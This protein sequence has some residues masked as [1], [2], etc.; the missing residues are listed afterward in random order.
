MFSARVFSTILALASVIALTAKSVSAQT[1]KPPLTGLVSMGRITFVHQLG[2]APD[3][4]L[5]AIAAAPGAFD[6][7]SIN[8][9]WDQLQPTPGALDT[10]VL[11]RALADV[12]AYNR[13]HPTKPLAVRLRV[14]ASGRSP[15]WAKALGGGPV[16]VID[17]EGQA[18]T[19]GRFW[20]SPFQLAWERLQQRLAAR[21]D[22]APLIA[23]VSISSCAARADEPFVLPADAV[24][25]ANLRAA[26]FTDAAY[27]ACLRA[28]PDAYAAWK[29]TRIDFDVSAFRDT[30]GA[31]RQ[32]MGFSRQ[33][34]ESFRQRLGA[35]AV[36]I[37]HC[38]FVPVRPRA[39]PIFDEMRALGPEIELQ[40]FS[41][42]TSYWDAAVT[43]AAHDL[44][45]N[46]VEVW[47]PFS[48][49]QGFAAFPV[50]TLRKWS[51]ELKANPTR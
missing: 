20:T 4:S 9:T 25:L 12:T 48:R 51:A 49:F 31:V 38:L 41:P 43:Y 28:A 15:A 40:M 24:S 14:Y 11:D 50:E 22:D 17:R 21:Y 13:A 26:G 3:N 8:V 32:D 2:A 44:K 29:R 27:R 34:M 42:E 46:V 18:I 19:I 45:A 47:P 10:S 7:V 37:N 33:I 36:L 1:I 5:D 6:G 30:E 35:R 16:T 39:Q 23:E